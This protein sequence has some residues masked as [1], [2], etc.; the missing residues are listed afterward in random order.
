[1]NGFKQNIHSQNGEDGI[2]AEIVKRLNIVNGIACEFGSAD[3]WW[4]S[5]IRNLMDQGWTGVQLEAKAGQFVTP[6][7]IN[8]LV[9]QQLDLLSIDIDGNDWACWAEYKGDAKVVIIE[10]NSSL[11][12]DEDF[13]KES[14]GAN[15]SIMCRLARLKGYELLA[16][17]GN[18]IFVKSE[19]IDLFPDKDLNFDNSFRC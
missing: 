18:C 6:E 17:T 13:F 5:N 15:F 1:M 10:I 14:H 19:Y 9:P 12:P 7:N 3:G 2:I 8:D 11:N 4:L 16:H